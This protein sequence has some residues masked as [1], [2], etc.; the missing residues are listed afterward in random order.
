VQIPGSQCS[1]AV[2]AERH[3]SRVGPSQ[4]GW[5][6]RHCSS[7][8][9]PPA[10]APSGHCSSTGSCT[11]P[12]AHT[13]STMAS[14]GTAGGSLPRCP[15]PLLPS[16]CS[17]SG[18]RRAGAVCPPSWAPFCPSTHTCSPRRHR[19]HCGAGLGPALGRL[20][21]AVCGTGQPRP[22]LTETPSPRLARTPSAVDKTRE[23]P[24]SCTPKMC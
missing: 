19:P 23:F 9:S 12:H 16:S 1:H 17:H 5:A 24:S 13:C 3:C 15:Q 4:G 6:F 10:P 14:P 11:G 2:T 18:T 20:E 8:G 22:L 7:A 21:P